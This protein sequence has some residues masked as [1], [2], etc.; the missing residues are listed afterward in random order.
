[1]VYGYFSS[2]HVLITS[3]GGIPAAELKVGDILQTLDGKTSI[4]EINHE[5]SYDGLMY[6]IATR[7][8][9]DPAEHDGN[10]ATFIANGLLV[11]DINA[12]KALQH[13]RRNNIDWVKQNVPTYLHT[14][15]ESHFQDK[16]LKK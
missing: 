10:I 4:L 13:L 7:D 1:M 5:Y 9:Q 11:G 14:D 15:V 2:N 6:N 3:K 16:K 8:H 12:Q